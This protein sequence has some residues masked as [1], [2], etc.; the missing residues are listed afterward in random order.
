M[1][2]AAEVY[3]RTHGHRAVLCC[4]IHHDNEQRCI[5]RCRYREPAAAGDA[6]PGSGTRRA[7]MA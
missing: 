7:E 1:L 5:F 2:L 6:V 3:L 4:K